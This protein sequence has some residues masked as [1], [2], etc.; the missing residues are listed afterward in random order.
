M[1]ELKK[2]YGN[3]NQAL[4]LE[5]RNLMKPKNKVAGKPVAAK[6]GWIREA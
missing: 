1:I 3:W 2:R 5:S 6:K 4:R